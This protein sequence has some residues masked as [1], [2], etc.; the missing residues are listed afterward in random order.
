[1]NNAALKML[2]LKSGSTFA[3]T[4]KRY[5]D[6]DEWVMAYAGLKPDNTRIVDATNFEKLPADCDFSGIII[7]GSHAMVTDNLEWMAPVSRWI[8]TNVRRHVPVLGICFGHQLLAR[9]MGGEVG[10]HPAGREIGT[11]SVSLSPIGGNDVLFG[12]MPEKFSAHA[13]HAQTVIRLP[14]NAI[15]LASNRFEPHH[16]FRIGRCAWGVQFH[17][18]FSADVMHAYIEAQG[19][20][21]LKAGCSISAL[22]AGVTETAAANALL[23]RFT[24]YCHL[25]AFPP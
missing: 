17:P 14:Q 1:M 11:V 9:A 21:L 7:T 12:G 15:C 4:R 25:N 22:N 19:D 3:S 13:T 10:Y 18:E 5:G 6:F 20:E 2:I 23:K 16:A 8:S 24:A